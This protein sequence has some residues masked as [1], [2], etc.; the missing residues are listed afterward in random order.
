MSEGTQDYIS[1]KLDEIHAEVRGLVPDQVV[2]L[3]YSTNERQVSVAIDRIIT[4]AIACTI[5]HMPE[6][7]AIK[8]AVDGV[9]DDEAPEL[10]DEMLDRAV[11][12]KEFFESRGM[13][14]PGKSK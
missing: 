10:T 13:E 8:N 1:G 9:P 3:L 4:A 6:L 11:S 2:E 5:K 14:V 12:G 7:Q